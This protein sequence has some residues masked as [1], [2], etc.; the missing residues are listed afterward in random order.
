MPG[1][2]LESM[3]HI[4]IVGGW[5]Y[6]MRRVLA[7]LCLGVLAALVGYKA[8]FGANG[9]LIYRAK[10]AEYRKL[11]RDIEE[12][13]AE[14]AQLERRVNALRTDPRAIQKEAREQL[15][16]VMPGEVVLLDAQP[17]LDAKLP[18][19]PDPAQAQK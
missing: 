19:V 4:R 10:Q 13:K 8:V 12:Q 18:S 6:R 17:K 5:F 9:M 2:G 14:N 1:L 3:F 11:Q 15:G 16:F 7:T